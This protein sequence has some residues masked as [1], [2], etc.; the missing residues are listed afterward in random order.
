MMI[1]YKLW[2]FA[3]GGIQCI[4]KLLTINR[5]Q[6]LPR[7]NREYFQLERT[8]K[9]SADHIDYARRNG[10]HLPRIPG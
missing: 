3:G 6:E 2:Y 9:F 8:K 10:S 5:L 1:V 4:E 7:T